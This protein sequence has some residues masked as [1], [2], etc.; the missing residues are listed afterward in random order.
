MVSHTSYE[1]MRRG[2]KLKAQGSKL[3]AQKLGQLLE[4]RDVGDGG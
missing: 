4:L 1:Y 3:K 2:S